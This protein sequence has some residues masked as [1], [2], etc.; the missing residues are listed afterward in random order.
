[1]RKSKINI[2][3]GLLVF[4][5][6]GWMLKGTFTQ[7]GIADLKGGF[8]E[9]SAY[10]NDNNTGPV[11]RIYAVSVKD[12]LNAAL[13]AYGDLMPHSKYGNTKV[14][15]FKSD[16]NIPTQLYPGA[17]NFDESYRAACFALYEKSA[18]GNSGLIK[19]P[20]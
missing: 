20:F 2:F 9:I 1:M 8:T 11:Q 15:F 17:V 14:Y 18:M 7:S 12:T 16:A 19:H 6:I 10:R 13:K 5:L 3:I 4:F